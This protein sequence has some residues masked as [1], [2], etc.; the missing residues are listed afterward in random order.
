M[1]HKILEKLVSQHTHE[2]YNWAFHK[3]SSATIAEDLVQES[4]LAASENIDSFKGDSSAKTWLFSILNHKI[5]DFYRK[6]VNEPVRFENK[7]F[8]TFFDEDGAWHE[9]KK[10]KEW[11][12]EESHLLDDMDFLK[13]LNKCMDALPEKWNTSVKLKYLSGKR[14]EEICQEMRITPTNLWQIVHRAKLSLRDC[15]E[16]NWFTN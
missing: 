5:I 1:D 13:V 4:F 3:T 7:I 12:E 10:P 8:S 15:I 16:N 14:G 6:K 11:N 9:G 2:L